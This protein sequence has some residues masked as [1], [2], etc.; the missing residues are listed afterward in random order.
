MNLLRRFLGS[1][2]DDERLQLDHAEISVRS[3]S[4][5]IGHGK[6]LENDDYLNATAKIERHSQNWVFVSRGVWCAFVS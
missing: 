6:P 4:V 2:Q 5:V 1:D 3:L